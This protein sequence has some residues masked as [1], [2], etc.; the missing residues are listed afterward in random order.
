MKNYHLR[1]ITGY[2]ELYNYN[3]SDLGSAKHS[4]NEKNTQ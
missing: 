2:R 4:L 3:K 1:N